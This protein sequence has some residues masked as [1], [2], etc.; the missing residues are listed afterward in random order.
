M[1]YINIQSASKMAYSCFKTTGMDLI[2]III[3][4]LIFHSIHINRGNNN[5]RS[6]E[7]S[8]RNNTIS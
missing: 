5:L 2:P 4:P 1:V 7:N 6:V 3:L 8:L